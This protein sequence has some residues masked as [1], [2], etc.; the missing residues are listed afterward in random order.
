MTGLFETSVSEA[1]GIVASPGDADEMAIVVGATQSTAGLSAFFL[2]GIACQTAIGYGD[3]SDCACELIEQKQ[4]TGTAPKR[5]CAVY[6]TA[7]T[8]PGVYGAI[9]DAGVVG[10]IAV[11]AD[12]TVVPFGSYQP[13]ILVYRG[14][15]VGS[16][17]GSADEVLYR[18]SLDDG[19]NYSGVLG[20]G[21]ATSITIPNSGC[22]FNLSPTSTN[23]TALNTL[24]Y[25]LYGDINAHLANVTDSVHTTS[26]AAHQVGAHSSPTTTAERVALVNLIRSAYEAH[27]VTTTGAL[28]AVHGA[29]DATHVIT[30]AIATND[31]TAVILALD[32]KSKYNDHHAYTTGTVHGASS[33]TN[34][35]SSPD[36][37]NGVFATGDYFS[38]RTVGPAPS[39]GDL[40]TAFSAIA[41]ASVNVGLIVCE[42]PMSSSLAAAISSGR[43]T[44][45][46]AGKRVTI[47]TRVRVR[48]ETW[49]N[50]SLVV[51]DTETEAVWMAAIAQEFAA[52]YNDGNNAA[53]TYGLLTDAMTGRR[54]LRSDLA[55]YSAAVL[56][57]GRAVM[58]C[59]PADRAIPG[60]SLIDDNGNLVGHDE[61]PRGTATGISNTTLGNR[62]RCNQRL[63]DPGRLEEVFSTVPW[64]LFQS[65]G[66]VR[67]L[68]ARRVANALER[69]AVSAGNGFMGGEIRYNPAVGATPA[70]LTTESRNIIWGKI[71]TALSANFR[72]DIQNPDA[73]DMDTGLVQVSPYITVAEGSLI[74]VSVTISPL[75]F[76]Y[77]VS[78]PVNLSIQQ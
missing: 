14:G 49:S 78:L 38:T 67:I 2:S 63:A 48:G 19:R 65:D 66:R 7:R 15:I 23:L 46:N 40:A 50:G 51:D 8:A 75:M 13:K 12:G 36:P 76:G 56:R 34:S 29:A 6:S 25:E 28:G 5:L 21:T 10:N 57:V 53:A 31:A 52:V 24:I 74:T 35:L 55:K 9:D 64:V 33:D 37:S 69:T 43:S 41:A 3:V 60:F 72:N 62:F 54:Y 30:A 68:P 47:T 18:Y 39:A 4:D 16:A 44:L 17:S 20:L 42:F 45:A 61:G 1:T 32:I 71:F 73:A 27:R 70:T 26:D 11:T 58:P 77:L 59:V 22:K